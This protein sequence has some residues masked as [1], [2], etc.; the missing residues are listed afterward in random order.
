MA[1]AANSLR[2]CLRTCSR[3][4]PSLLRSAAARRALSTTTPR[5]SDQPEGRDANMGIP[6]YPEAIRN[7]LAHKDLQAADRTMLQDL[8]AEIE[9]DPSKIEFYE[10]KFGVKRDV[11]RVPYDRSIAPMARTVKPLRHAFWNKREP[12]SDLITDE[13]GEDDWEEN[14]MLSIA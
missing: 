13:F 9:A 5:R 7:L 3:R 6:T 2:H 4:A 1:S 8:L 12:E 10:R 11:S 14:D